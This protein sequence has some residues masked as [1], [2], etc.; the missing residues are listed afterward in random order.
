MIYNVFETE[1]KYNSNQI[2]CVFVVKADVLYFYK[3]KS[4]TI[5]ITS[6][7]IDHESSIEKII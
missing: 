2:Y 4:N 1:K 5:V 3:N 7:V 6:Y